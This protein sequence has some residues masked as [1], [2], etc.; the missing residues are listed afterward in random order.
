MN[1]SIRMALTLAVTAT[2][3]FALGYKWAISPE[4]SPSMGGVLVESTKLAGDSYGASTNNHR[5]LDGG[6]KSI[7][8]AQIESLLAHNQRAVAKEEFRYW[9]MRDASA[10]WA[11][12]LKAGW[13]TATDKT[14]IVEW[15][16][17]AVGAQ[18]EGRS[19]EAFVVRTQWTGKMR[20]AFALADEWDS[21]R[22]G[23]KLADRLANQPDGANLLWIAADSRPAGSWL[24][25]AEWAAKVNVDQKDKER[26]IEHLVRRAIEDGEGQLSAVALADQQNPVFD[27]ALGLLTEKYIEQSPMD[28]E[29]T[30]RSI[31][32][33]DQKLATVGYIIAS[34]NMSGIAR[35]RVLNWLQT[36]GVA[37][38]PQLVSLLGGSH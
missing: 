27:Q 6:S 35:S 1:A 22:R 25:T 19:D 32:S 3:T 11:W 4:L 12:Y 20:E 5:Q 38:D 7:G 2:A 18:D 13:K 26:L 36:S 33:P 23:A 29:R 16:G 15:L 17:M 30:W 37:L 28:A 8:G 34:P 9:I 31:Q 24:E 21:D 10:A 14:Q